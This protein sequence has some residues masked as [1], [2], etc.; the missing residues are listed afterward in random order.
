MRSYGWLWSRTRE[1][2]V[3][4]AGAGAVPLARMLAQQIAG[5][6]E[7]PNPAADPQPAA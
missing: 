6:E 1:A 5:R 4:K 2:F 3:R 7:Q